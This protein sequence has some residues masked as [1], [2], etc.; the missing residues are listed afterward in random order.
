M[1]ET[2]MMFPSLCAERRGIHTKGVNYGH[3]LE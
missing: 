1:H 2:D 3:E